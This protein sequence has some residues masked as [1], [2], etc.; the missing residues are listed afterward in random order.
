[1]TASA[2]RTGICLLMLGAVAP[3]TAQQRPPGHYFHEANLPPGTVGQGQL[4]H[5]PALRG[6][7]QPVELLVPAGARVAVSDGSGFTE[8]VKDRLVVGLE[9]GHVYQ[10]QISSIPFAEGF[11]VFPT[12]E[13]INRLYPP[14]GKKLRFPV[15]VQFT[16]R[17]LELALAGRFVTRV[18]Y[19]ESAE[20]ALPGPRDPLVQDYFEVTPGDDP[21]LTAD[22]LGRPMAIMR[23]GSRVPNLDNPA[24]GPGCGAPAIVYPT[25]EP[26]PRDPKIE[27]AIERPTR[28]VPRYPLRNE[29][30]RQFPLS[31]L[32]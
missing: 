19:L 25:P 6:Y 29:S 27:D 31:E 3:A 26:L 1:M 22:Q 10:F 23:M 15:P 16:Q 9:V 30:E 24:D 13:V 2:I 21:L 20:S 32:P 5:I 14:E 11:A 12:I 4:A 28:D 18:V 7:I 8:P 17:E